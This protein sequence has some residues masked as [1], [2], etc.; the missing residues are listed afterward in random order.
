[1][2]IDFLII[3]APVTSIQAAVFVFQFS[4]LIIARVFSREFFCGNHFRLER[5]VNRHSERIN[6]SKEIIPALHLTF[7]VSTSA[8]GQV[9]AQP[10]FRR[11][12][13]QRPVVLPQTAPSPFR[14]RMFALDGRRVSDVQLPAGENRYEQPVTALPGGIYAVQ[15]DGL[16]QLSGSTLI[17]VR[18]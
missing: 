10:A 12:I 16:R 1:M 2:N 3:A 9:C 7:L 8:V 17:R 13:K 14:L 18:H 15:L 6:I 4:A 5:I 11:Q